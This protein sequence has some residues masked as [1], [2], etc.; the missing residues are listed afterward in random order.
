ME[1]PTKNASL[2]NERENKESA[3]DFLKIFNEKLQKIKP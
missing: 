1:N 2:G 3:P